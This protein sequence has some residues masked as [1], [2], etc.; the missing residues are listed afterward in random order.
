MKIEEFGQKIKAKYPEYQSFSDAEIGQKML[1]KYPQ[2]SS[3]IDAPEKPKPDLLQKVGSIANAI[4]PGKQVGQAIG[5]LAGAGIAKLKGNYDQYDLSAPTPL[6][7]AGDIGQGALTVASPGVGRGASA[8]GRIGANVGL[9]AG[10]GATG[11]IAKGQDTKEVIKQGAIGGAIGGAISGVGEG[12]RAVT[13]NLPKWLTRAA[14]PKLEN[15]N[16]DYTL[17]NVKLGSLKSV[18]QRSSNAIKGYEDEV[19]N[20][21]N[22]IKVPTN[23]QSVLDD[24]VS[25]FPNAEYTT[26]DLITNAKNIAPKVS[27]LITKFQKGEASIQ[28][29][30]TIR[31]ELDQA[32]KSVYTSLNRP[33][34]AK[35]LGATLSGSMR[36][37]VKKIAPQTIPV[38]DDYSKEIGLNKA[39]QAAVKKGEQKITFKDII[40]G[41]AG[42]SQGGLKGALSAIIAERLLFNPA[43]QL[44]TAQ[45]IRETSRI[46]A[47]A[48]TALLQGGKAPLIKSSNRKK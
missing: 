29:L 35:L 24:A 18:Q 16:V 23:T 46:T 12:I 37:Y 1:A 6:Q 40:A 3:Q 5:T 42:F 45:I 44:G 22:R 2:Y 32:T 4:F 41:G 30:N 9:G 8:V 39:I 19:Q 21:L 43:G 27:K 47:P 28:E 48:G 14:L 34:E 38:F 26:D 15:K 33:P 13:E 20:I 36:E 7:V 25:N 11:A 31:K 10:L 17:N